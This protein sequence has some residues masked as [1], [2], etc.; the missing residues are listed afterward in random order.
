M[1]EHKAQILGNSY[2]PVMR[3]T[4]QKAPQHKG[5]ISNQKYLPI[6]LPAKR[7]DQTVF[8]QQKLGSSALR[9]SGTKTSWTNAAATKNQHHFWSWAPPRIGASSYSYLFI[10]SPSNL[11]EGL[12]LRLIPFCL[13]TMFLEVCHSCKLPKLNLSSFAAASNSIRHETTSAGGGRHSRR[14]QSSPIS[15][16]R[17]WAPFFFKPCELMSLLSAT[18]RFL[19]AVHLAVWTV[20]LAPLPPCKL[21]MPRKAEALTRGVQKMPLWPW[22]GKVH[23]A[24]E[25]SSFCLV[26]WGIAVVELIGGTGSTCWLH[27]KC[28]ATDLLTGPCNRMTSESHTPSKL[29][30]LD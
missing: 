25:T 18:Y 5:P 14:A 7:T 13:S 20:H 29:A 3:A 21:P 15:N 4:L 12:F 10:H 8:W 17:G 16:V 22:T 27:C 30:Y 9:A 19:K 28:S 24:P 6:K 11:I 1:H 2:F 23:R 26:A